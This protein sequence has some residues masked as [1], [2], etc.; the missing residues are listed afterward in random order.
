MSLYLAVGRSILKIQKTPGVTYISVKYI[1]LYLYLYPYII[2]DYLF[3]NK[4]KTK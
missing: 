3:K 1:Y 4:I 2:F